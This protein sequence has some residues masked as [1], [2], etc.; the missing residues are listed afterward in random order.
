MGR[1]A[2]RRLV[3]WLV[4]LGLIAF[5][6]SFVAG[7][8]P[9]DARFGC[10]GAGSGIAHADT[11][12]CPADFA[13]A[14]GDRRWAADRYDMIK[15]DKVTT[16]LFYDE[17]GTEHTFISGEDSD[18][19]L[20]NQI[21]RQTGIPFPR[22]ATIH[23]AAAHVEAKAASRMRD[24]ALHEGIMVINNSRGVCGADDEAS[25]YGCARVLS[26]V[27]PSQARLVIWWPGPRGMTAASFV[28]GKGG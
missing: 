6:I 15:N 19:D 18:A 17:D 21:L 5:G 7:H 16:G 12:D 11:A 25:A 3:G 20:A 23:P 8:W 1:T 9:D 14:E 24:S 10:V 26:A 2:V 4:L 28:G 22:R 13:A 27:L